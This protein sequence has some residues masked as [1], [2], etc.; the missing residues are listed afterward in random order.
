MGL[1]F[2]SGAAEEGSFAQGES[3]EMGHLVKSIFVSR[4]V[5]LATY[6]LVMT[7]IAMENHHF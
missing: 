6:P 5:G 7:N 3:P 1:F 2:G 4:S